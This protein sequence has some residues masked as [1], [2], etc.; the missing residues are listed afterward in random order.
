MSVRPLSSFLARLIW[1]CMAPLLLVSVWLAWDNVREQEA[2]HLREG[3]HLARNFAT[4]IDQYLNARVSALR[5]LADSP[6]ADDPSRWPDLYGEAKGFQ[7]SFGTHVIFADTARQMLFNTRLPYGSALPGLPLSKGRS[8]A[9]LVLETGKPQV[10]DI[11]VGPVANQPL[12]AIVVP[13]LRAGKVAHL[14]L[15]TVEARQ[16]QQR[17]DSVALPDGW[18]LALR[19]GTGAGI[20]RR[21]PDG[22]DAVRDVADD[23]RFVV[24]TEAAAWSVVVE[25]PRSNHRATQQKS[26]AILAAAIVLAT[27]L[28]LLG[29]T[30]AGRRIGQGV[31][32]L[33]MAA[34]PGPAPDI[35]EFI[36]ARARID[37][38]RAAEIAGDERFPPPARPR[39]AAAGPDCRRRPRPGA[40]RTIRGSVRLHAEDIADAEAWFRCA[41]PIRRFASAHA[42][43]GG[44]Q[45]VARTSP[46]ANTGLP[47]RMVANATC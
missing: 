24:A 21:A 9:P 3:A 38:A 30:L 16:L 36:A 39:T 37:E 29:G 28:G 7:N 2:R 20:A 32:S 40:Q 33:S 45:P 41:Y 22:F 15:T 13:G 17:L 5:M 26:A 25:I 34:E 31:K 47:A 42:P 27:L 35:T 23:H 4:S 8:A 18:A 11:V 43:P 10:G 6:L 1:L 44:A 12:L 46:R 14:V 19:D